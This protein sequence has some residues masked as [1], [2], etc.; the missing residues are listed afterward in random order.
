MTLDKLISELESVRSKHGG[1][2]SVELLTSY[3]DSDEGWID[4]EEH[5]KG[6]RGPDPKSRGKKTCGIVGEEYKIYRS[7]WQSP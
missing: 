2:I 5:I 4:V 6:V 7:W 1:D 3:R